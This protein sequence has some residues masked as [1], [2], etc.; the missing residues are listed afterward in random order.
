MQ[1]GVKERYDKFALEYVTNGYN[2]SKA[3]R[4]AKYGEKDAGK[5]AY[6]LLKIKYIKDKIEELKAILKAE[7]SV[8]GVVQHFKEQ[9]LACV[10]A[11]DR[12][13]AIRILENEAKIVG[14]YEKD[15]AQKAEKTTLDAKTQ[16]EVEEFARWSIEQ[17]HKRHRPDKAAG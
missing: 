9:Y 3:A 10:A 6:R 8:E 15:N 7:L 16:Q 14:A 2:G 4:D 17:K 13:N 11:K 1:K 12:T 5:T